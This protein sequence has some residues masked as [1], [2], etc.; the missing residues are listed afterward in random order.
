MSLHGVVFSS[1]CVAYGFYYHWK[2]SIDSELKKQCMDAQ[3]LVLTSLEKNYVAFLTS[4][5]DIH[6]I[7]HTLKQ[8]LTTQF[9]FDVDSDL[10]IIDYKDEE[11]RCIA[12]YL[13]ILQA[14]QRFY[15]KW[16]LTPSGKDKNT[17]F[18]EWL[19]LFQNDNP[20]LQNNNNNNNNNALQDYLFQRTQTSLDQAL[21][22]MVFLFIQQ[23]N[24]KSQPSVL[25]PPIILDKLIDLCLINVSSANSFKGNWQIPSTFHIFS[26]IEK[27]LSQ[28]NS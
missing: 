7:C 10:P 14:S 8:L 6:Y 9:L 5:H 22:S 26:Q 18:T 3:P 27:A 11:T 28:S 1:A 15:F 21:N 2:Q 16:M 17:F 23:N 19:H 20:S 13:A 24:K 4:P 12:T 25:T